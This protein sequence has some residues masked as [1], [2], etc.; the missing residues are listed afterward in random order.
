MAAKPVRIG[1]VHL[2]L[3]A[4]SLIY[5]ASYTIAKDVMNAGLNSSGFILIRVTAGAAFFT[6]YHSIFVRQ[7]VTA[8]ADHLGL[9]ISGF[10]GVA[11]NMLLFFKGLTFT[12][13]MNASVLMLNAPVFVLIFSAIMIRKP[14]RK[15][16]VVGVLIAATGALLL[17]GG[18]KFKYRSETALGDLLIILNATCYA[19]YLVFVRKFLLKYSA[20]T[21]ARWIF[22]Y[23]LLFVIPF[24]IGSLINAPFHLFTTG[25]WL[26]IAFVVFGTTLLAYFLNAWSVQKA[27]PT[28]V[29]GYIYLQPVF[30]TSIAI[31]AQNQELRLEKIL[32]ALLIFLGVYLVSDRVKKL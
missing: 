30:A 22:T 23:G 18:T 2:A 29:A 20:L 12:N 1:F 21:V 5:G 9:A 6:I 13:E 8:R 3:L 32:F 24:G 17:I 4:V 26:G 11:A 19:F 31:I 10:F 16:Q 14:V 7:K 15:R 28:L 25:V 27:S